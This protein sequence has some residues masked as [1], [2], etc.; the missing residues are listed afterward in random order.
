MQRGY[1]LKLPR[2]HGLD[3]IDFQSSLFLVSDFQSLIVSIGDYLGLFIGLYCLS[4]RDVSASL[5][6]LGKKQDLNKTV[7]IYF[8]VDEIQESENIF[9]FTIH[10][11]GKLTQN[12]VRGDSRD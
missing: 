11:I 12:S 3:L 10:F 9:I 4:L 6:D 2:K 8:L 5:T 1:Q 7:N